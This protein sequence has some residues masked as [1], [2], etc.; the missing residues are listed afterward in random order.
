MYLAHG[1]TAWIDHYAGAGVGIGVGI[2][3]LSLL[4]GLVYLYVKNR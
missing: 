3:L 4:I 1:E 2:L